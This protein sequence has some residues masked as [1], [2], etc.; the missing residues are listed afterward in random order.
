MYQSIPNT[1]K[2][3]ENQHFSFLCPL[4]LSQNCILGLLSSWRCN[5]CCLQ[6]SG[7]VFVLYQDK[8]IMSQVLGQS[9]DITTAPSADLACPKHSYTHS[10]SP[11]NT[12]NSLKLK[13]DCEQGHFLMKSGSKVCYT[14]LKYHIHFWYPY[15]IR[16]SLHTLAIKGLR[17]F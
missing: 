1:E 7:P 2:V 14:S 9:V 16:A 6:K 11:C 5:E 15:K 13:H 17:L 3:G 8:P 12:N 10:C 4:F